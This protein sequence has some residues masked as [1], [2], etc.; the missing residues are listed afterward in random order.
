MLVGEA[1]KIMR[2]K[3][4]SSILVL[5]HIG[6]KSKSDN[7]NN[8]RLESV[9]S[10]LYLSS[11]KEQLVGI[12]TEG[13]IFYRVMAENKGPYKVTLSQIMSSPLITI[14]ENVSVRD[15]IALMQSKQIR[16]LPVINNDGGVIGLVTLLLLFFS[17]KKNSE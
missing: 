16:R 12:L 17:T 4:V 5:E 8:G 7:N 2:D 9:I 14:N 6:S 13:D 15:A 11:K 10:P 1:I 3:D